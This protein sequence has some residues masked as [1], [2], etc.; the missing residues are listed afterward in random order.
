MMR[1]IGII[2]CVL[3][4]SACV[5]SQ[6]DKSQLSGSFGKK[7]FIIPSIVN[8][9]K[10]N[11]RPLVIFSSGYNSCIDGEGVLD[12]TFAV[13]FEQLLS[14]YKART[15]KDLQYIATCYHGFRSKTI[16]YISDKNS[17]ISNT[18][19]RNH[20]PIIELIK[21]YETDQIFFFGHSYGGWLAMKIAQRFKDAKL[22][23]V[24]PI[25]AAKCWLFTVATRGLI[26]SHCKAFPHDITIPERLLLAK[27][28]DWIHFYQ[29]DYVYLHSGPIFGNQMVEKGYAPGLVKR[30]EKQVRD[31]SDLDNLEDY[32]YGG[33]HGEIS[34][35]RLV[36]QPLYSYLGLGS[37][38][39]TIDPKTLPTYPSEQ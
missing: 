8:F 24:D 10:L 4:A 21:S 5:K 39:V 33:E 11:N 19:W 35:H 34:I 36:W 26:S 23:T 18:H 37:P 1:W 6:T 9:P 7:P 17:E 32:V 28:T 3:S 25:S 15:G 31:Y 13:R 27:R 14:H 16:R 2:F 29:T 22:V 20:T 30:K 38:S 12:S